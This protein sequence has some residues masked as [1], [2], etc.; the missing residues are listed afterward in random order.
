M[1]TTVTPSC[2]RCLIGQLDMNKTTYSCVHQGVF[3]SI[4][5]MISW[6]CDICQYQEFDYDAITQVEALVG[7]L[8]LPADL[9]RRKAKLTQFDENEILDKH[10]SRLKP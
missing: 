7:Q 4:P 3:L 8:G 5:N 1:V 9:D 10:P 2:P 6:T